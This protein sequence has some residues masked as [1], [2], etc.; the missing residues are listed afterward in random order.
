MVLPGFETMQ[1]VFY[2]ARAG[3]ISND[4]FD[5]LNWPQ[6]DSISNHREKMVRLKM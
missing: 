6:R 3:S 4:E 2:H 1:P 5:R